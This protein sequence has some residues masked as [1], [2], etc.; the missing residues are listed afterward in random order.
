MSFSQ[1]EITPSSLMELLLV[2]STTNHILFLPPAQTFW[3]KLFKIRAP[4]P[5]LFFPCLDSCLL[6]KLLLQDPTQTMLFPVA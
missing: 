1:D 2:A 6:D 5:S 4:P 3:G